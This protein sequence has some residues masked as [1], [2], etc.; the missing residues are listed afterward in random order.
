MKVIR[1]TL[2]GNGKVPQAMTDGGYFPKPNGGQSPQDYDMIGLSNGWTGL[3]EYTT[4]LDFSNYIK[5]F[6][7]DEVIKFP[8]ETVLIDDVIT[9]FWN[10][11]L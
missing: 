4:K 6:M 3:E 10:R 7:S 5:S 2:L 11:S 8:S 1:Y 9:D